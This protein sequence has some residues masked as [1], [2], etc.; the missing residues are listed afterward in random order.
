MLSCLLY[1]VE[2][3]KKKKKKKTDNF[4][5]IV[6]FHDIGIDIGG[7]DCMPFIPQIDVFIVEIVYPTGPTKWKNHLYLEWTHGNK[8]KP[9]IYTV[10]SK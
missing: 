5:G 3:D 2:R 4:T 9:L 8:E 10:Q 7:V 6:P 1:I